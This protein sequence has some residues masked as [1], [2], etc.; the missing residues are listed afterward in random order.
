MK[1]GNKKK[2]VR[3]TAEEV[4]KVRNLAKRGVSLKAIER[5]TGIPYSTIN[6]ILYKDIVRES[7]SRYRDKNK[8]KYKS[9]MKSYKKA[10][11][12]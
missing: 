3:R 8:G 6:Y 4:E 11:K 2:L 1:D 10:H 7:H 5:E 12:Q 9:Y